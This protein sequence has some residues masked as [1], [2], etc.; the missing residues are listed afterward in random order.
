MNNLEL[1]QTNLHSV[2]QLK[3]MLSKYPEIKTN[4]WVKGLSDLFTE[5]KE[6]ECVLNLTPE[7]I[8]RCVNVVAVKCF[9]TNHKNEQF[10]LVEQKQFFKNG[11]TRSRDHDHLAEKLQSCESPME[12]AVRGLQ[13]ELKLSGL[14]IKPE[15]STLVVKESPSYAGIKSMYKIFN[16]SCEIFS[17]KYRSFYLEKQKDKDTLFVWSKV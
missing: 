7:G 15:E 8:D 5:I 2:D 3:E 17:D 16:F 12:A 1:N 9:H 10:K 11:I 13:E 14:D 4:T 6:G